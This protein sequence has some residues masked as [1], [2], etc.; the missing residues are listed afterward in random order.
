LRVILEN[1]VARKSFIVS[2]RITRCSAGPFDIVYY[3]ILVHG[4]YVPIGYYDC[5][6]TRVLYFVV[7]GGV[8]FFVVTRAMTFENICNA[9]K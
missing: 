7:C 6:H 1:N 5:G 9:H 8:V 3:S 2:E 4:V